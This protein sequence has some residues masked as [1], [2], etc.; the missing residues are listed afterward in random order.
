[1]TVSW[2]W[3]RPSKF[4][5]Y[6][7]YYYPRNGTHSYKISQ[8][9]RWTQKFLRWQEILTM[10]H[11]WLI[12]PMEFSIILSS[13]DKWLMY[14]STYM[15]TV[16]FYKSKY[17]NN[18]HLLVSISFP[19]NKSQQHDWTFINLFWNYLV[20]LYGLGTCHIFGLGED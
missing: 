4:N 12:F 19:C 3:I 8:N 13:H 18:F 20:F 6:L 7:G 14:I 15:S 2:P 10:R 11:G 9:R 17:L 1:M 16:I 5:Q